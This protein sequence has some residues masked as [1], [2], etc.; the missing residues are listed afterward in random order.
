LTG[1]GC[2]RSHTRKQVEQQARQLLFWNFFLFGKEK[3]GTIPFPKGKNLNFL[4]FLKKFLS[5]QTFR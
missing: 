5:T 1:F 3:S 4:F 2:Y